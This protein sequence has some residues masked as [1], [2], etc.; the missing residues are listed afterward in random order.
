MSTL[1]RTY[2]PLVVLRS[3]RVERFHGRPLE[4]AA[5]PVEA[6]SV[7]WA[8]PRPLGAVPLDLTAEMG[9]DRRDH[10]DPAVV[11]PVDRRLAGAVPDEPSLARWHLVNRA[12]IRLREVIPHEMGADVHVLLDEVLGRRERLDPRGVVEV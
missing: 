11:V 1:R 5:V 12:G 4:H 2:R 6:R 3:D 10:V 9:A 8:I 7:A